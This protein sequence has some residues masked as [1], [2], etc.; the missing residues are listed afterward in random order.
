MVTLML[1]IRYIVS[2]KTKR[3][4]N[5]LEIITVFFLSVGVIQF[6]HFFRFDIGYNFELLLL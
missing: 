5:I 1:L 3:F 4:E 2:F 6:F